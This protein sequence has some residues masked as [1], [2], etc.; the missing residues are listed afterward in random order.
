MTYCNNYVPSNEWELILWGW[1]FWDWSPQEIDD[2]EEQA[3]DAP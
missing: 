3:K 2:L 1:D